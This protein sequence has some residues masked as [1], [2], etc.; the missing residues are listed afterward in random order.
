MREESVYDR[1][2]NRT[3]PETRQYIQK[4]LAVVSEVSRLME[5]KGWTQKDLAKR[6]GKQESQISRWLTGL[7]NLTLKSVAQLEIALDGVLLEVPKLTQHES[8]AATYTRES[9]YPLKGKNSNLHQ[10]VW[11]AS[12][13]RGG[14][15]EQ[16]SQ[17]PSELEQTYM[18]A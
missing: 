18:L 3:K 7:H 4:N 16:N 6:M 10:G 14:W 5:D 15:I 9:Y 12:L 2:R 1:I 17:Q 13:N 11:R 8:L